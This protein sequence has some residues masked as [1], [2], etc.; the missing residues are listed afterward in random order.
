MAVQY[1]PLPEFQLPN[2]NILGSLAQGQALQ[3]NAL[4]QQRLQQQMDLAERAAGYTANRDLREA[5]KLQTEERAKA[6]ELASKKYDMLVGMSPRLTPQNYKA[7]Y[8]EVT[9]AFPPAASVLNP[10]YDPEQVKLIPLQAADMKPQLLQ[11]T[12]GDQTRLLRA[13]P[14]GG[15]EVVPGSE[16]RAQ[17]E[18]TEI[19]Q[20]ENIVGY[21]P[22]RGVGP[23]L[24]PEEF[25]AGGDY[26]DYAKRREGT[27]K[28]PLSSAQNTGQFIDSTFV[29]T[30]RK[31]FPDKAQ[32]MSRDQIL[33]QRGVKID[34][35][36]TVEDVMLPVLTQEN[37]GALKNAGFQPSKGNVYLSHFLGAPDAI[38]VLEARPDTPVEE[39]LR[40]SVLRSNPD[41][42]KKVKTAGDLVRWAGGA[43]PGAAE[44]TKMEPIGT[45]KR[46]A[47]EAALSIIGDVGVDFSGEDRVSKLIMQSTSGPLETAASQIPRT[48]GGTTAGREAIAKLE[49]LAAEYSLEKLGGKLGSGVSNADV[50][51]ISK[52]M[53][54][55]ANPM[56]PAKE[57]L[58]AW[59]EVKRR[60][61]K[62]ANI[63]AP[64]LSAA[65][66]GQAG[67]TEK[68]AE[69]KRIKFTE[70]GD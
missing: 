18:Y 2:V 58:A 62:Y 67:E 48:F 19:K 22:K 9:T 52:T 36:R 16:F 55:I 26:L 43:T 42:F 41:V 57:R 60:L 30:Y 15:A 8:K 45:A 28:N 68:P 37:V 7:W 27:G 25:Q 1:S 3:Q 23:V 51:F 33:A 31:A 63:E 59:N 54:D 38:E 4:Q 44:P 47:Q 34:A 69:R 14:T 49:P 12:I 35:N 21:R 50:Q 70:L 17:P 6:F 56:I 61:A 64:K 39:L 24:T 32:G 29:N 11:Q 10:E 40:P 66:R 5:E 65:P 13:G 46:Q 53:G 20:G